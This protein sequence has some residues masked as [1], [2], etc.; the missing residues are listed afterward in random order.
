MGFF[1][2]LYVDRLYT[3]LGAAEI[4]AAGSTF[5]RAALAASDA[6]LAA[7]FGRDPSTTAGAPVRC[8]VGW[9]AEV[10]RKV[11]LRMDMPALPTI[12]CLPRSLGGLAT[13]SLYQRLTRGCFP[14]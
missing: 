8:S 10:P 6:A 14:L 1:T 12:E 11:S 4:V 7:L 13:C 5:D 9:A 2:R 3:A